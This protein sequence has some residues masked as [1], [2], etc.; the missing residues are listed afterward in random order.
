M[1]QPDNFISS[2]RTKIFYQA[3]WV[4]I[5]ADK[6]IFILADKVIFRK[7]FRPADKVIFQKIFR[8]AN[9]VISE[10]FFGRRTK[11]SSEKFFGR[12]TKSFS[13]SQSTSPLYSSSANLSSKKFFSRQ[14]KSF[15]FCKTISIFT[16]LVADEVVHHFYLS[17]KSYL[18]RQ[19]HPSNKVTFA[20]VISH[21]FTR[22]PR[23]SNKISKISSMVEDS[24]AGRRKRGRKQPNSRKSRYQRVS[25]QN[26]L[27]VMSEPRIFL[28]SR[29]IHGWPETFFQ[30]AISW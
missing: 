3:R 12:R 28:E 21:H 29:V 20:K 4:D 30:L 24:R 18:G 11:S 7:I 9:K 13:F 6:V 14:A 10:K 22:D 1:H 25:G 23:K 5:S 17:N 27:Y 16:L 8:P 15:S 26:K 2:R 19:A